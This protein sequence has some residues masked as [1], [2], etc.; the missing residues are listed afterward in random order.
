MT[1]VDGKLAPQMTLSKRNPQPLVK[2]CSC[3]SLKKMASQTT[4]FLKGKRVSSI[5]NQ[6]EFTGPRSSLAF[7]HASLSNLNLPRNDGH[8]FDLV[9]D[10]LTAMLKGHMPHKRRDQPSFEKQLEMHY[11]PKVEEEEEFDEDF[12]DRYGRAIRRIRRAR[13]GSNGS[14]GFSTPRS[15]SALR[16]FDLNLDE[17]EY[18]L[19]LVKR[20]EEQSTPKSMDWE[21]YV[22]ELYQEEDKS[23]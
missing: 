6:I 12:V 15:I 16:M 5:Q 22:D 13:F 9:E 10:A 18:D 20:E 2:E 19:S 8:C 14:F 1:C 17:E 11:K 7:R 4:S 3:S 23:A 21:T